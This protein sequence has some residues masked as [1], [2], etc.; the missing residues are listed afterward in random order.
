MEKYTQGTWIADEK[1]LRS[2]FHDKVVMNGYVDKQQLLGSPEP[3][4]KDMANLAEKGK[5][6]QAK[7]HPY[8]SQLISADVYGQVATAVV[9]E[10]G[11]AGSLA[12]TDAFHLIKID[13]S[14]KILSKLFTGTKHS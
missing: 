7:N 13:G 3:F 6:F 14:W 12:F 9:Q 10:T 4:F 5:S 1:L 2:I 11:Y 8:K